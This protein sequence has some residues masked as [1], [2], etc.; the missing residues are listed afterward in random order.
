MMMM[1]II[2][3][4]ITMVTTKVILISIIRLVADDSQIYPRCR[5]Q[6]L[7]TATSVTC[8]PFFNTKLHL[9]N[10]DRDDCLILWWWHLWHF[11]TIILLEYPSSLRHWQFSL[12]VPPLSVGCISQLPP[13]P[14][15]WLSTQQLSRTCPSYELH[16][17]IYP[18]I[19][20]HQL[21]ESLQN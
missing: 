11:I 2:I 5:Q 14:T 7:L 4:N 20:W 16:L 19:T 13:P 12:V 1:F 8:H 18:V 6:I 17:K 10:F 21:A 15:G 9:N 3:I